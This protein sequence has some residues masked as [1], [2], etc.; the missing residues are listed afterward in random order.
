[1]GGLRCGHADE[2]KVDETLDPFANLNV[3]PK[4]LSMT[5]YSY[6]VVRSRV[7][8]PLGR[9]VRPAQLQPHPIRRAPALAREAPVTPSCK[10][11]KLILSTP[12]ISRQMIRTVISRIY[13]FTM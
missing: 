3:L 6:R 10:A 11:A 2:F 8:G 7:A 13:T 12:K 5:V 4:N 9:P 1:L